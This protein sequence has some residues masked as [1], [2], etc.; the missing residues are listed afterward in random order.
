MSKFYFNNVQKR[1]KNEKK[2]EMQCLLQ[3]VKWF[4]KCLLYSWLLKICIGLSLLFFFLFFFCSRSW[5]V[6]FF[7]FANVLTFHPRGLQLS[8]HASNTANSGSRLCLEAKNRCT[9]NRVWLLL[10]SDQHFSERTHHVRDEHKCVFYYR[11][12]FG[13]RQIHSS[14]HMLQSPAA[15]CG[16]RFCQC[17]CHVAHLAACKM[18]SI[19]TRTFFFIIT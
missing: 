8:P 7:F 14:S 19:P 17:F 18:A 10:S 16:S 3:V 6:F 13:T 2:R 11:E 5:Q 1:I 15:A 4:T 9:H 12:T